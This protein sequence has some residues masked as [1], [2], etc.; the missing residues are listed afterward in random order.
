MNFLQLPEFIEKGLSKPA[1]AVGTTLTS[2]WELVFGGF[3]FHVQKVQHKRKLAFESFKTEVEAKI[4]SIP[5]EKLTEPALYILGPTLEASKYYFEHEDLRSMFANLIAAALNSDKAN[6]IHPS[7]VETIKQLSPLD[8]KNISLFKKEYS[9]P[10]VNYILINKNIEEGYII[11]NTN[12]F[13]ENPEVN[14]IDL[15]SISLTNLSRLGL[16]DITYNQQLPELSEY[17]KFEK[18]DLF[19]FLQDEMTDLNPS[20]QEYQDIVIKKGIVDKT[21]YGTMFINACI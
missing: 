13:L 12:V 21:T 16:V 17:D 5:E 9:Y 11:S 8:A 7:F 14:D 4:A 3:D 18:T 10:I 15:N 19:I 20:L 1:E 6:N 2:T